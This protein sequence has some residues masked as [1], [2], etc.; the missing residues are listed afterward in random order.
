MSTRCLIAVINQD[1]TGAYIRSNCDGYPEWVGRLLETHY[2][3]RERAE[4]IIEMG[5]MSSLGKSL[6]PKTQESDDDIDTT[7]TVAHHR[8]WGEDLDEVKARDLRRGLVEFDRIIKES[9]CMYGYAYVGGSWMVCVDRERI[10]KPL[11]TYQM[12]EKCPNPLKYP[13]FT[14][15]TLEQ[16]KARFLSLGKVVTLV[17]AKEREDIVK[18]IRRRGLNHHEVFSGEVKTCESN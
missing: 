2:P 5:D 11:S 6:E 4:A 3:T 14:K 18:E 7:G 16:L 9:D 8:D 12:R 10:W 15:Y 17:R 1:G 13:D